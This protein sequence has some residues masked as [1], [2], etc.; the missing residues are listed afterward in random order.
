MVTY[1]T[2]DALVTNLWADKIYKM[3]RFNLPKDAVI[4][5]L[6]D[7]L[8]IIYPSYSYLELESEVFYRLDEL[9]KEHPKTYRAKLVNL[10]AKVGVDIYNVN[11][12]LRRSLEEFN[13]IISEKTKP[14]IN[15]EIWIKKERG[16]ILAISGNDRFLIQRLGQIKPSDFKNSF[17]CLRDLSPTQ[18]RFYNPV[19]THPNNLFYWDNRTWEKLTARY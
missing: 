8:E 5:T 4:G 13:F 12:A 7:E 9:R 2:L 6:H 3:S 16:N 10:S 14:N 11:E 15:H 1:V 18:K 17:R 19:L